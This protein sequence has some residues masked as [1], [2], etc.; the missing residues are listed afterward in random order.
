MG[1]LG[2]L[3]DGA[4]LRYAYTGHDAGRADRTGADTY[5]Y[6]VGAGL[7]EEAGSVGSGDIAY[8]YIYI[9]IRSL[10]LLKGVDHVL[11]M[12]VGRIDHHSVGTGLYEGLHAI[13][14]VGSHTYAG[15]HAET[16]L[17]VFGGVGIV[18]DLGNVAVSDEAFEFAVGTYYRKLLDLV[19]Q[20]DFGGFGK[21]GI[22][23][24][25]K[26]FLRHH[27]LDLDRHILLETKVAV[28]HDA[29]ELAFSVYHGYASDM[30]VVHELEGV[31]YSLVAVDGHRIIDHT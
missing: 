17:A 6:A 25:D 29:F 10:H 3:E 22:G 13:K 23:G 28:G 27:V 24:S 18:F 8:H 21:R 31:A 2:R 26:V 30:V 9:R 11:A 20:K 5:L 19:L 12:A 15:S 16:T 14:S 4:E 7:D 1:G